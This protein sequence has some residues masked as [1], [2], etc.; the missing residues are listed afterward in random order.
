MEESGK[1]V[2]SLLRVSSKARCSVV[3][4]LW[5]P[6]AGLLEGVDVWQDMKVN[7]TIIPSQ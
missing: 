1:A 4:Q 6:P 3:R 5:K 2:Y 7:D